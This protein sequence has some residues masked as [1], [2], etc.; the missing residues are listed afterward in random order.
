M[1]MIKAAIYRLIN[2]FF[3]S[4]I[5]LNFISKFSKCG[6]VLF[7][8]SKNAAKSFAAKLIIPAFQ[9]PYLPQVWGTVRYSYREEGMSYVPVESPG[10]EIEIPAS[11]L[12]DLINLNQPNTLN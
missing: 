8:L 5:F 6:T 11:Y 10:Y 4:S 9:N 1:A 2:L 7:I 3:L 12:P